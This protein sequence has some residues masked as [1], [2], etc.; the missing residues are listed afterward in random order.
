[1]KNRLCCIVQNASREG[2]VYQHLNVRNFIEMTV[3]AFHELDLCSLFLHLCYST[4]MAGFWLTWVSYGY[5]VF[6][7]VSL[8]LAPRGVH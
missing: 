7:L 2:F 6:S 4:L 8:T 5:S 3:I 1:M